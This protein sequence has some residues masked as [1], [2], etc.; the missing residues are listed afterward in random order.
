[1]ASSS[2]IQKI[3]AD[4]RNGLS[5]NK[6][7]LIPRRKNMR[8]LALLGL[9]PYDAMD[10]IYNLTETDYISGP[11]IDRDNPS[12]DFFWKFKKQ[13]C[14]QIFYIKFKVLYQADGT[15]NLVSFHIDGM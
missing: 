4:M 8:S 12:S 2:E 5:S 7:I 3:L 6:F 10:E 14:G 11:D 9:T 15:V 1:M 13:I